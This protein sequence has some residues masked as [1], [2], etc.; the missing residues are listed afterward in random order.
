M[1]HELNKTNTNIGAPIPSLLVHLSCHLLHERHDVEGQSIL[2]QAASC[3][4]TSKWKIPVLE[5][6]ML[7]A[8]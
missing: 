7:L 6:H 2:G 3:N 1:R 5:Y 4:P 8:N